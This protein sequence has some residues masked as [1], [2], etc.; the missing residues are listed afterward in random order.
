V[1]RLGWSSTRSRRA[2]HPHIGLLHR[3]TEKLMESATYLQNVPYLDRLDMSPMNQST[4]TRWRRAP[5]ESHRCR[6]APS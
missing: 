4:P 2:G 1:L 6:A 5:L 3:G